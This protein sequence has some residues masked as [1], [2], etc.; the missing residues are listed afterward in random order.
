MQETWLLAG[1]SAHC[2][3]H[4]RDLATGR[5]QCSLRPPCKRP[6]YW[7]GTVLTVTTMQET[8]PGTVL[9]VTTMQETWLL[10]GDSAHCDHHARDLATGRGQCS[11]RPPCKRPGYWPGTV[12][13]VTT[14][15]ETWLLAGDSAHCDHHARDLATGRGQCSL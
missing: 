11:L 10:A 1:D 9:T 12:L 2:D 3:H 4:A 8:W 15:Q 6:G 13:T 14:M 7:P 5:G